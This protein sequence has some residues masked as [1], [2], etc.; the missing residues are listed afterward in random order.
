MAKRATPE[1]FLA[2]MNAGSAP[3]APA[4]VPA[5]AAIPQQA[6]EDAATLRRRKIDKKHIGGY[7]TPD[8]VEKFSL[9][10]ARLD[11][12]NSELLQRAIE[13]L[14]S[15]EMAARKFGDR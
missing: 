5:V 12:D 4:N 1:S 3:E 11:L 14:F 13:E 6:P 2:K 10:R 15:R 8:L 7:F 9:L